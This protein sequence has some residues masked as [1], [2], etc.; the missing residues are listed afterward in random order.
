MHHCGTGHCLKGE[1]DGL[2]YIGYNRSGHFIT[3]I[4]VTLSPINEYRINWLDHISCFEQ[5]NL[6]ADICENFKCGGIIISQQPE[7][8]HLSIIVYGLESL[9]HRVVLV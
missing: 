4:S 1:L 7:T 3:Q 6:A 9:R 5:L 8:L 2:T